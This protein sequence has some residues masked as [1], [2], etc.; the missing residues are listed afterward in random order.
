MASKRSAKNG[1]LHL[2]GNTIRRRRHGLGLSQ[3]ELAFRSQL[4]RTY[5]ADIERGARNPSLESINKLAKA[6]EY[7]L[8][9]LFAE[10]ESPPESGLAAQKSGATTWSLQEHL[11]DILLVEDNPYDAELA[12]HALERCNLGNHLHTV[13]DGAEALEFLLGAGAHAAQRE[14]PRPQVILLDLRLPKIDGLNVLKRIKADPHT[15]TIPVVV[16]TA[17]HEEK[18]LLECRQLGVEHYLV[19]PVDFEQ[20]SLTMPRVGLHWLLLDESPHNGK[21]K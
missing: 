19:K 8:A 20:F 14:R 10:T 17:S 16:L 3:E 15:R 5:V 7:S 4:H 18:D 9:T 1:V 21:R 13:R 2:L 11:V 12:V 6:L